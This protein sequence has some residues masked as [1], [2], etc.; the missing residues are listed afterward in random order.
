MEFLQFTVFR[1]KSKD[2]FDQVEEGRRFII[3]RK[4]KP[5]ARLI[6]FDSNSTGWKR[7]IKKVR[8]KNG[9]KS[10]DYIQNERN[11]N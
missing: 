8:L 1:N 10:I 6:P 9:T 3:I 7:A 11:E 5:V 4:G 2:Y